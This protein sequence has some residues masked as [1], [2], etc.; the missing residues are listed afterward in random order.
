MKPRNI[1]TIVWIVVLAS[2]F[3]NGIA[4]G[5]WMRPAGTTAPFPPVKVTV[6][7]WAIFFAFAF[8]AAFFQRRIIY[9]RG[10]LR[11]AINW[12]WGAGTYREFLLRLKLMTLVM[13][14]CLTFGAVG[15]GF[16]PPKRERLVRLHSE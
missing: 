6:F 3:Y 11:S 10:L 2:A 13:L 8:A 1:V 12:K 15:L 9:D 7:I 4:V 5:L 14:Y 16:D